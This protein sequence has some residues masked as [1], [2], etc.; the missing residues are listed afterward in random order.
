M[1]LSRMKLTTF[2][3][4][5]FL[6][7]IPATFLYVHAGTAVASIERASDIY[8]PRLVIAF[9]LLGLLPIAARL[10]FRRR[11]AALDILPDAS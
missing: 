6:G 11:R 7:L 10:A 1:G 9:V 4:I 5:S 3:P 2:A 8:S